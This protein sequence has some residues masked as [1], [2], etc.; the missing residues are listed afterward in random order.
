MTLGGKYKHAPDS[1]P[2]PGQ[3]DLDGT[4]KVKPRSKAA[5]IRPDT[6]HRVPKEP[7][8]DP[9]YYDGHIKPFGHSEK[10]MTMGGKYK[11][12]PDKN[13]APG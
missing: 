5:V 13:P 8:P 7:S 1:N 11:F 4:R 10:N 12:V 9:G 3:Y 6:G 2:A